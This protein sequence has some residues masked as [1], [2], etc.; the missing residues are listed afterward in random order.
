MATVK[1]AAELQKFVTSTLKAVSGQEREGFGQRELVQVLESNWHYFTARQE[2]YE[3]ARLVHKIAMFIFKIPLFFESRGH[4]NHIESKLRVDR[5]QDIHQDILPYKPKIILSRSVLQFQLD[6]ILGM[7]EELSRCELL[8]IHGEGLGT[9]YI[10]TLK[11]W[12]IST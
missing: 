9:I 10:P 7:I 5:V 6:E 4:R 11:L 8:E 1:N 2:F 3:R 12:E